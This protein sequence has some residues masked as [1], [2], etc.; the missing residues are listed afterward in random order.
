MSK[1]SI[2]TLV[3]LVVG[4][5]GG[6]LGYKEYQ[7]RQT[8]G[9]AAIDAKGLLGGRQ[10]REN[11]AYID[12]LIHRHH[13]EAFAAAFQQEHLFAPSE[14]D[15]QKYLEVLWKRVS[16]SAIRD[17]KPEIA[18]SLPSLNDGGRRTPGEV[19]LPR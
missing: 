1:G 19:T 13:G 12:G 10:Y 11:Q 5:L 15:E 8:S 4:V 6:F 17:N 9:K 18:D 2:I 3:V 16:E 14:F 7:K